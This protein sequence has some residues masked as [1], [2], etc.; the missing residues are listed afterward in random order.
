MLDRAYSF[1]SLLFCFLFWV[2][3][4]FGEGQVVPLRSPGWG[5]GDL[6][7]DPGRGGQALTQAQETE[8]ISSMT[9]SLQQQHTL[10]LDVSSPSAPEWN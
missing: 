4:G 9:S 3:P 5:G 8:I 1:R 6:A 10:P 7:P 2:V